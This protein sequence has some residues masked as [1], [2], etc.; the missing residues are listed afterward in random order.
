MLRAMNKALGFFIVTLLA[1]LAQRSDAAVALR[2]DTSAKTFTWLGSYTTPSFTLI[3]NDAG[4]LYF[5]T[6]P[7]VSVESPSTAFTAAGSG[8]SIG[9]SNPLVSTDNV[10]ANQLITRPDAFWICFA[11]MSNLNSGSQSVTVTTASNGQTYSYASMYPYQIAEFEALN[12][13]T[14]T[15]LIYRTSTD[16]YLTLGT[17][18]SAGTVEVVPEPSTYALL[19]LGALIIGAAARRRRTC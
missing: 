14:L 15:T 7:A 9:D 6:N 3:G 2:I 8:L 16:A 10:F 18:G 19:G 12:G 13:A 1:V 17:T 11:T 4:S 5:T